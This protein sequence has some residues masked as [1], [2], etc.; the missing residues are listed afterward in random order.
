MKYPEEA[1]S[2]RQKVKQRLPEPCEGWNG[3]LLP[4]ET[5]FPLGDKKVLERDSGDGCTTCECNVTQLY[6]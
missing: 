4:N 3:Q 1:N 2:Q 6:T 5:K